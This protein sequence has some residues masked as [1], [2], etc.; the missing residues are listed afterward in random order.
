MFIL[1][2]TGGIATGK[3]TVSRM[4]SELGI[5]V[6]DAD[7]IAREVVK[8]GTFGYNSV[9]AKFNHLE[10][11]SIILPDGNIDRAK[12]GAIIFSNPEKRKELNSIL[13]PLI[14]VSMLWKTFKHYITATPIVVLDVPLLFE[15]SLDRFTSANAVVYCP[16]SIQEARLIARDHCDRTVAQQR[17]SSQLGIEAK[18]E[19]A[20]WVIDNSGDLEAT[21]RSVHD[22]IEKIR[23]SMFK[24]L[25][26]LTV[27]ISILSSGLFGIF[28]K[29]KSK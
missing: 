28:L 6:I 20:D 2:I 4:L 3:S 29:A 25:L 7:I 24:T 13:H 26:Q 12:L 16:E 18:R 23:P 19:K 1:G 22:L 11:E 14:R 9:V 8:P 10:G 5:P 15:S 21:R 17:M 27:P